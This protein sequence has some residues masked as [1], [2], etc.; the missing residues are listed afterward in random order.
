MSPVDLADA[1][2]SPSSGEFSPCVSPDGRYLFLMVTLFIEEL[3]PT[4]GGG[5]SRR[6]NPAGAL[7][8]EYCNDNG[9]RARQRSSPSTAQYSHG[10]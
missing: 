5:S 2:N 9:H 1:V 4:F 3:R 10:E 6:S 7:G 8:S